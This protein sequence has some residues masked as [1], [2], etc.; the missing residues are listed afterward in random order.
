[1]SES[2]RL[3]VEASPIWLDVG[4]YAGEEPVALRVVVLE[5]TSKTVLHIQV[6]KLVFGVGWV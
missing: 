3:H 6:W 2:K 4:Y 5:P 1:M